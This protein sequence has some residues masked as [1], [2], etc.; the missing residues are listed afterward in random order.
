MLS[1]ILGLFVIFYRLKK[2]FKN[3]SMSKYSEHGDYAEFKVQ[4]KF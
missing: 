1:S 4:P 3:H 2:T